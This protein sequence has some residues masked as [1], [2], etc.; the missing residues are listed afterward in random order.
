MISINEKEFVKRKL[1]G[2]IQDLIEKEIE[3]SVWDLLKFVF[4]IQANDFEKTYQLQDYDYLVMKYNIYEHY[5]SFGNFW[6]GEGLESAYGS[7]PTLHLV[8]FAVKNNKKIAHQIGTYR[9]YDYIKFRGERT[10][11]ELVNR[12]AIDRTTGTKKPIV[13]FF[14]NG[15]ETT[16]CYYSEGKKIYS[17]NQINKIFIHGNIWLDEEWFELMSSK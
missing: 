12:I 2:K 7:E 17:I 15:S 16:C 11:H 3:S 10:H 4:E 8:E 6:G 5:F 13:T 1:K 9:S 14:Y